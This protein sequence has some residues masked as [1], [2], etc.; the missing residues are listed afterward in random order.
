MLKIYLMPLSLLLIALAAITWGTTGTTLVLLNQTVTMN[1]L[2]VGFW[3]IALASPCL[4]L[5]A[6]RTR[7]L[8]Y[9][10]TA[11]KAHVGMGACIAAYQICYFAAVPLA[12][13]AVTALVAICSSPL[14]IALLAAWHLG[15]QLTPRLYGSLGLGVVGTLLLVV[16]PDA[17]AAESSFLLG[18]L[19]AFGAAL[20]YAGYAVMAKV[21][22]GAMPPVQSAAY[23]F[24][25]AAI[26]LL[27]ALIW[28][29]PLAD[30]MRALPFLLYLGMVTTAA[31]YAIY[32]IGIQR[33][34]A[35]AAGIT[36][37]LEPLT[38]TL[39]GV[40]FFREA[41]PLFSIVGAGLLLSAIAL[42]ALPQSGQRR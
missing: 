26:L 35:T 42:L 3:R 17:I 27:P 21:Q 30:W 38:A 37:L 18:V 13:V 22:A 1:P 34:S 24:T 40:L 32:M 4:L 2:A 9:Q 19:L 16:R 39:I 8:G 25:A 12:G 5:L 29:P 15:E 14:L 11:W 28:Q 10:S 31:A 36:V 20:A 41:M 6:H 7:P 23:G 33:I